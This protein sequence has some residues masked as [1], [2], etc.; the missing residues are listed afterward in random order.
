MFLNETDTKQI[1]T[2]IDYQ[3]SGYETILPRILP[4]STLIRKICLIKK[5][6][7]EKVECKDDLMV[8]EFPSI[9]LEVKDPNEKKLAIGGFYRIF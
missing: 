1:I 7:S 2:K 3:I 4:N 5:D 6:L 8:A 9:W